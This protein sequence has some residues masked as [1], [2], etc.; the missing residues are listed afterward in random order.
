ML[1][2]PVVHWPECVECEP[3]AG[4]D[5]EMESPVSALRGFYTA[6]HGAQEE[7]GVTVGGTGT[8]RCF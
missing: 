4:G 6:Q 8:G 1:K 3:A 5:G 2:P 7:R